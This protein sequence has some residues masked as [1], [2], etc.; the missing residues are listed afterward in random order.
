ELGIPENK[1]F[2]PMAVIESIV[3]WIDTD[4]TP[5]GATSAEDD[6][7][8]RLEKPYRTSNQPLAD[9]SELYLIRGLSENDIIKLAPYVVVRPKEQ[10]PK[11][12]ANSISLPLARAISE[13]DG[14][15]LVTER[16]A[17]TGWENIP[18]ITDSKLPTT[19]DSNYFE[20]R[21]EIEWGDVLIRQRTW[22]E[23]SEKIK[24]PYKVH[25]IARDRSTLGYF[26]VIA[27]NNSLENNISKITP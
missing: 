19:I 27:K 7:Y 20:L 22:L 4:T 14:E 26:P 16:P 24:S 2:M 10:E 1:E 13:V 15:K 11:I 21:L 3:D 17:E 23:R 18:T 9:I 12:N 25:V 5:V 8:S 6:Y